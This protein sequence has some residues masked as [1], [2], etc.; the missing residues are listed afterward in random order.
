[1]IPVSLIGYFSY[2]SAITSIKAQTSSTMQGTL[3]QMKENIGYQT[4]NLVRISDQFF[5]DYTFQQ[6]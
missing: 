5:L 3:Q 6:Q 1:V 4:D 2:I